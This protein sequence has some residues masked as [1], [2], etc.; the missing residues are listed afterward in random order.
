MK[1]PATVIATIIIFTYVAASNLMSPVGMAQKKTSQ[2]G[3]INKTGK[4]VIGLQFD[5]ADSFSE[6]LARVVFD[7]KS[8]YI[9]KTG[10]MVI[11]PQFDEANSFSEGLAVVNIGGS[12]QEKKD[13]AATKPRIFGG[14]KWGYINK[15]GKMVIKPQFDYAKDF[16]DG[17]ASVVIGDNETGGYVDKR[18][19][20]VI[21]LENAKSRQTWSFSEGLAVVDDNGGFCGAVPENCSYHYINK[22]GKIVIEKSP[23]NQKFNSA[24]SFSEGLAMVTVGY[25]ESDAGSLIFYGENGYIDKTGKMVIKPQFADAESFSE[26]LA[27]VS[28]DRKVGY[29]DKT[30][31]MVIKPQFDNAESFSEGLAVVVRYYG[32]PP[33]DLTDQ[34]WNILKP[35]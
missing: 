30:G 26:G 8:G 14:G 22:S 17:L 24:R 7:G 32:V 9:N 35:L 10:K 19:K 12:Y 16:S 2:W 4:I 28:K 34:Q 13:S 21:K 6:G 5:E 31:K 11:R 3:Y 18:G 25:A 29:I 15:T 20:L 1:L 33:T 27:G 23:D